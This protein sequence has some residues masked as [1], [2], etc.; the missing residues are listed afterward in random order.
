MPISAIALVRLD[1]RVESATS[2][3]TAAA[4]AP[5]PCS[6]RPM[7]MPVMLSDMAATTL[8]SAKSTRPPMMTGL[9]PMRS[10]SIPKGICS[11]ACVRP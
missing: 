11:S 7:M 10:D 4:I 6:A 8:P 9:R 5:L 1:S 3:M 2:A